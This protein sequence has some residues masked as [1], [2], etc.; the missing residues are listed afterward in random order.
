MNRRC[1]PETRGD[2]VFHGK[3]SDL[4]SHL[5]LSGLHPQHEYDTRERSRRTE[6]VRD[7]QTTTSRRLRSPRLGKSS[8]RQTCPGKRA[9]SDTVEAETAHQEPLPES[10]A[11][12]AAVRRSY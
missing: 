11:F 4:A 9:A 5:R 8:P 7:R 12:I 6:M 10:Q 2:R 3:Q 1:N